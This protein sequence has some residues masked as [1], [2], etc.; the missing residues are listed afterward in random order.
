VGYGGWSY[1]LSRYETALVAPLS[2]LVPVFGLFSAMLL[3]DEHLTLIQWI[4]VS[5]IALGLTFN[6]FGKRWVPIKQNK[7]ETPSST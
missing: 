2:L 4:G 7:N 5:I 6:M 3:L 1:L